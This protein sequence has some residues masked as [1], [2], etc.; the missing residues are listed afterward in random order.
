MKTQIRKIYL[1]KR[2]FNTVMDVLE[3]VEK[4]PTVRLDELY[5]RDNRINATKVVECI[6]N[7]NDI[8]SVE[9][10]LEPSDVQEP[11][12]ILM[13]KVD[14]DNVVEYIR[15]KIGENKLVAICDG[16]ECDYVIFK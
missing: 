5:E 6:F 9:G 14:I 16:Y 3:N 4:M 10:I 15:K 12:A 7:D 2:E 8:D 1:T 13:T 11:P